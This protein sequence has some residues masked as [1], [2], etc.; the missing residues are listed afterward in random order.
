MSSLPEGHL[1]QTAKR[2]LPS[3][4]AGRRHALQIRVPCEADAERAGWAHRA[5]STSCGTAA[6]SRLRALR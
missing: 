4:R 3:R 5:G 2:G 1:F 6:R